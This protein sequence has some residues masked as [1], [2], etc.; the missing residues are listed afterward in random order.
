VQTLGARHPGLPRAA[1]IRIAQDLQAGT[2]TSAPCRPELIE[3]KRHPAARVAERDSGR[4][5][6]SA[7]EVGLPCLLPDPGLIATQPPLLQP[8]RGHPPDPEVAR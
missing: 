8:L 7:L 1:L 6:L 2:S 5:I 3:S 4:T